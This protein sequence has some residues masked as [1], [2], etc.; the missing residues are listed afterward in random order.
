MGF[1]QTFEI[2]LGLFS[3][4]DEGPDILGLPEA[5]LVF[6]SR[7]PVGRQFDALLSLNQYLSP[8][9]RPPQTHML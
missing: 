9:M 3:E 1:G 5:A 7:L 8:H 4:T 6:L 2:D